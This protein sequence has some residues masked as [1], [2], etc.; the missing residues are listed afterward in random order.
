MMRKLAAVILSAFAVLVPFTEAAAAESR[1]LSRCYSDGVYS[2]Y[3]IVPED[4]ESCQASVDG[5]RTDITEFRKI[6][7][8]D[9]IKTTF[10][11]DRGLMNGEGA[12]VFQKILMEFLARS[13][14]N[15]SF[16][17]IGY[18]KGGIDIV[19]DFTG[20]QMQVLN[21]AGNI[22]PENETTDPVKA[23]ESFYSEYSEADPE[24]CERAV[25][26]TSGEAAGT[27]D[28]SDADFSGNVIPTGFVI[29]EDGAFFNPGLESLEGFTGYC[30]VSAESD[31]GRAAEIAADI[32]G[33]SFVQL[34]LSDRIIG[35]GGEKRISLSFES[36]TRTFAFEETVDTGDR[37]YI[38]AEKSLAHLRIILAAVTMA[39]FTL[40]AVLVIVLR[41]RK[42]AELPKETTPAKQTVPLAG[43]KENRGTVF[44]SVSTMI[45]FREN[46]EK[47][48]TLTSTENPDDIIEISS[49]KETTI[50]RNQAMCDA[51]I[52]NERSVSQKHCRIFCRNSKVYAED[53]DSLNHTY[54]DGEEIH[55]ETE[56]FSGSVLKIGR[57][58]Y[59]VNIE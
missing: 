3:V 17:M 23:L 32:S 29:Y 58:S 42:T 48:I 40:A 55:E 18:G 38:S 19:T 11:A 35:Q 14:E 10:I 20:N 41:K 22:S 9:T 44:G 46:R 8:T 12:D 16:R 30:T 33:I 53:L 13:G 43:K 4:T 27:A 6:S 25:V 52:Y 51:V 37:R 57:V 49:L 56:L 31:M 59:R 39:A 34:E 5:Q 26:F 50:G 2:A 15:E 24:C 1:I 28:Y 45:L 7:N 21:A 47:K 36:E 54:V